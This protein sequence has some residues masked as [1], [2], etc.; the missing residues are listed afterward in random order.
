[1]N[2]FLPQSESSDTASSDE[3]EWLA[4]QYVLGELSSEQ[5]DEF[6]DAMAKDLSLCDDVM[7]AT[8]M[9]AATMLACE[10]AVGVDQAKAVR[11]ETIRPRTPRRQSAVARINL[12]L[13]GA[14]LLGCLILA[15]KTWFDASGLPDGSMAAADDSVTAIAFA[16]LLPDRLQVDANVEMEDETSLDDS[17]VGLDAPE[18]LLTAV[19]LEAADV[20]T[21]QNQDEDA[22]VF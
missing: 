4:M 3:R 16:Q 20:E 22:K 7:V 14:A 12:C 5:A 17:L 10:S 1:M 8:R 11:S 18:W 9:L 6:E 19:E 21:R 13:M 15:G 2:N